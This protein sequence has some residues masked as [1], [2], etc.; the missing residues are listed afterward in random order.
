[1]MFGSFDAGTRMERE[2]RRTFGAALN[3]AVAQLAYGLDG[4]YVLAT[5]ARPRPALPRVHDMYVLGREG[6]QSD[7]LSHNRA[8]A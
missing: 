1:M 5:Q 6:R 8:A 3:D 4:S 7:C 2:V